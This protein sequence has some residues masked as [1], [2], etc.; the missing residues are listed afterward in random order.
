[1]SKPNLFLKKK[2]ASRDEMLDAGLQGHAHRTQNSILAKCDSQYKHFYAD[3]PTTRGPQTPTARSERSERV[4]ITFQCRKLILSYRTL[5]HLHSI[6][7]TV[8]F[9]TQSYGICIRY[10]HIFLIRAISSASSI[11]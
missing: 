7:F 9:A 2:K 11:L 3:I 1:M 5:L 8:W 10:S 4:S 6:L